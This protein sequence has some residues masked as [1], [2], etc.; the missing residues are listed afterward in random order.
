ML[1]AAPGFDFSQEVVLKSSVNWRVVRSDVAQM[2]WGVIVRSTVMI[3]ILD[4][5]LGGIVRV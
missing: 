3:D 5:E 1:L 4:A 2:L